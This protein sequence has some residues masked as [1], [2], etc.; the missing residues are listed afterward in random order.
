VIPD[1]KKIKNSSTYKCDSGSEKNKE[2]FYS[3][4][5]IPVG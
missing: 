2:L 5:D 4:A 1:P 3:S